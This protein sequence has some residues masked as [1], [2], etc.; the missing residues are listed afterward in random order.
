MALSKGINSYVSLTEA[1]ASFVNRL[2][3]AAWTDASDDMK[4]QAL[5][6]ATSFL[7]LLSWSGVAVSETQTLA[8]PRVVSYFNPRLGYYVHTDETPKEVLDATCELAYHLLNNDGLLDNTGASRD[9]SVGPISLR[10]V[11]SPSMLPMFVKKRIKPLLLNAGSRA[12][13]RAN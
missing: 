10:E 4:S 9:I 6:T 5:T 7:D 11:S 13:W 8:F 3:V 2:D 1:D 12:W